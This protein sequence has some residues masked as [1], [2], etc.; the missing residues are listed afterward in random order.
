MYDIGIEI[1]WAET[2]E[3]L[4]AT[5][6]GNANWLT[7]HEPHSPVEALG[8][9]LVVAKATQELGDQNVRLLRN[10]YSPHVTLQDLDSIV[11]LRRFAFL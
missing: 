8:T 2:T 4:V 1:P 11:P 9:Q 5:L 7:L 10:V 3:S 6:G